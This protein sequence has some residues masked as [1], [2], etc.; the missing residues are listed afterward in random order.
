MFITADIREM[1]AISKKLGATPAQI[2]K[3]EA[4]A[5]NRG[6]ASVR[7]R[8]GR[9]LASQAGLSPGKFLAHRMAASKAKAGT[10]Y[11]HLFA[12]LNEVSLYHYAAKLKNEYE[13]GKKSLPSL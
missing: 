3:A 9:L 12:G 4:R 7:Q 2:E 6:L 10:V 5:I 8:Y 1:D 11:A 13:S